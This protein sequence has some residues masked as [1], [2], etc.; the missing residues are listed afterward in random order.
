MINSNILIEILKDQVK[1]ALGCTE[2]GAVALA[3]ARS[4]EILGLDVKKLKISVNN[5]IL[6]NGLGVGIP[7]TRERGLIFAAA[8]SLVVGKSRYG[9]E[10]LKDV[11]E[12]SIKQALEITN[13]KVIDLE[14]NK[15]A[16]GLYISVE[17][18]GDEEIS[19]V[20]IEN[21]HTNIVYESKNDQVILNNKTLPNDEYSL[22]SKFHHEIKYEIQ[23]FT[24]DNLINFVSHV[25][26]EKLSFI[27]EG[28]DMN[29]RL[30]KIGISE[31]LGMGLGKYLSDNINDIYEKAKAYTAGASEARMSGYPLPV[32]SSAGSGNHGL[33]AIIPINAIGSG[34]N[35]SHDKIVRSVALSHLITIY[36][37]S[38]IGPLSPVCGCGVAAGVGCSA[39]LTF[40][41]GGN[42]HQIKGSMD[43]MIAGLTGMICDGAKLGCSYKLSIS[44]DA[45][46][47]ASNMAMKNIFVPID[48]GILGST[49]EKTIKNLAEISN[50]GMNNTDNIILEVMLNKCYNEQ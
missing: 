25:D 24:I 20:I 28:I 29:M 11:N 14:L 6:K 9:L 17:A 49:T 42:S 2:P 44:V 16:D 46:V 43:N 15:E 34:L 4:K 22:D 41:M 32:M 47:D 36:V 13:S 31:K 30:A 18:F 10:V 27:Q 19:K 45:A 5:N 3:V 40:M 21:S 23:N 38:Y 35:I 33:V 39:G 37:K 1:P 50:V 48:N 26:I 8:L 12:D 7:G